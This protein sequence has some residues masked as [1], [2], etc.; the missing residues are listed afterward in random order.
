MAGWCDDDRCTSCRCNAMAW[1]S[2]IERHEQIHTCAISPD[3]KLI[4]AGF[5]SKDVHIRELGGDTVVY[6]LTTGRDS[7]VRN[8]EWPCWLF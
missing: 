6:S 8:V 1:H 4:A 5:M 2:I 3:G 7:L